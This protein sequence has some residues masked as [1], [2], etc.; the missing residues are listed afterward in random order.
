MTAAVQA[1]SVM[2]SRPATAPVDP[3][4]PADAA[5]LGSP[6]ARAAEVCP[7]CGLGVDAIAGGGGDDVD[8][9]GVDALEVVVCCAV[10][11]GLLAEVG[12]TRAEDVGA[13]AFV[14]VGFALEVGF[15]TTPPQPTLG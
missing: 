4:P 6:M 9:L 12:E 2:A 5:L 1:T 3:P 11:E 10:P 15:A 7:A 14:D 13:A 8:G